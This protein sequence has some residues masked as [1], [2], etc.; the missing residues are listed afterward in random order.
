MTQKLPSI[1]QLRCEAA[2]HGLCL[3][4]GFEACA[5]DG[6][7]ECG[8][9]QTAR[10]LLLFG[11]VGSSLW[12]AFSHSSEYR[13]GA[14]DP[15]DRWSRRMGRTLAHAWSGVALFPFDGPPW[16]PFGQWAQRAEPMHP[17]PLGILIHPEYGLWHAYR[18]AVVLSFRPR[19]FDE[20]RQ[21]RNG[22]AFAEA[23]PEARFEALPET[24]P[25]ASFEHSSPAVEQRIGRENGASARLS[26][27]CQRCVE[28]ACLSACPVDA[29]SMSQL[30]VI[31]CLH[32]LNE[33]RTGSC[34][35][36]GCRAR[37]ACPVAVSMRYSP[38]HGAFHMREFRAGLNQ[39]LTEQT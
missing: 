19:G 4:G 38:A 10:V 39:R 13:D 6:L 2:E 34:L 20:W 8:P 15:L 16:H 18:F 12:P 32:Y 17:S 5:D 11:N 7:P 22:S 30:D 36:N 31:R 33:P 27:I 26:S 37:N 3:R 28:Q 9:G 24:T 29:L 23:S 25:E 1:D 21:A 14:P 35:E